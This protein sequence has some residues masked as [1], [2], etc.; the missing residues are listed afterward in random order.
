MI[1]QY[2]APPNMLWHAPYCTIEGA[3]AAPSPSPADATAANIPGRKPLSANSSHFPDLDLDL[4]VDVD[5]DALLRR[6]R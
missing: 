5:L 4:D 2:V 6:K 1:V 3:T